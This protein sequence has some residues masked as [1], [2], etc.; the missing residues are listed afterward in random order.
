MTSTP[1]FGS[2][3]V[4]D[5]DPDILE[6]VRYNLEKEGFR[7]ITCSN[8]EDA[9]MVI[10]E[11]FP[12]LI[13]LDLMMPDIGGTELC[14]IVRNN[15][16]LAGIKIIMLTAR[17]E[18]RD[19]IDGLETGADDYI[20]KP[21]SPRVLMARVKALLRRTSGTEG[22]D[23]D[24]IRIGDIAIIPQRHEVR[25]GSKHIL[26]TKSEYSI[27]LLM[28]RRPGWVYSRA[29]I[30]DELHGEEDEFTTERTVDVH[31]A[32]LRKKLNDQARVIETVR[33]V[34]YRIRS[35]A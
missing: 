4:V 35:D 6:L 15:K 1:S 16:Q 7:A 26:L 3:V 8:G 12:E 24:S 27:L 14:R 29:K 18:E 25:S 34:G 20:T 28:A 17:T 21:F 9:L 19:V 5:D 32:S 13:I 31:I 22:E 30:V 23:S 2:I 11:E 10:K 33:G